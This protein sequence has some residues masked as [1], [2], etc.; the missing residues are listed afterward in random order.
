MNIHR[1]LHIKAPPQQ[2]TTALS[3]TPYWPALTV[4]PEGAGSR[5]TLD[6]DVTPDPVA[7][8]YE[9]EAM[10]TLCKTKGFLEGPETPSPA[11][12]DSV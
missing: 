7:A 3:Q 1:Q 9:N 4:V 2:V 5:V 10:A 11:A 12:A 6:A 8:A